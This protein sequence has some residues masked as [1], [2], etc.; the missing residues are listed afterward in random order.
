MKRIIHFKIPMMENKNI[1]NNFT[2]SPE[3][4]SQ[5]LKLVRKTIEDEYICIATPF[6]PSV[7]DDT[8]GFYNFAMNQLSKEELMELLEKK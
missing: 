6:E 4:I 5:F 3:L 1:K 2:M 7:L 8:E